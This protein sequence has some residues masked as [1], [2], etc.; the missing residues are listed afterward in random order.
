MS[1]R[2]A[3]P[4]APR[5]HVLPMLFSEVQ[6]LRVGVGLHRGTVLAAASTIAC[7][8][9]VVPTKARFDGPGGYGEHVKAL[10]QAEVWIRGSACRR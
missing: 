3:C 4:F 5:T 2:A 10:K 6:I 1:A 9:E 8:R 7:R